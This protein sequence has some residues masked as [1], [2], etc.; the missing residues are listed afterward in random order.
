[1][2]WHIPSLFFFIVKKGTKLKTDCLPKNI[3]ASHYSNETNFIFTWKNVLHIYIHNC[4]LFHNGPIPLHQINVQYLIIILHLFSLHVTLGKFHSL[5]L[6]IFFCPNSPLPSGTLMTP[7]LA[8]L[9]YILERMFTKRKI[10]LILGCSDNFIDT[11]LSLLI[12]FLFYWHILLSPFSE[13]LFWLY[14]FCSKISIW[15]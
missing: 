11:Y 14:F 12:L 13:F 5:S 9:V 3:Y 2:Y 4:T 1:M 6:Q 15:F 7:M 10:F 8:F